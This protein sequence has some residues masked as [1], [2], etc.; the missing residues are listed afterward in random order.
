LLPPRFVAVAVAANAVAVADV[1][2]ADA[3]LP[4]PGAERRRAAPLAAARSRELAG[5]GRRCASF[6][7]RGLAAAAD[8]RSSAVVVVV[9]RGVLLLPIG[10]APLRLSV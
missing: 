6:F 10:Q 1:V 4:G 9:V 3:F 5:C 8:K 2:V 7:R